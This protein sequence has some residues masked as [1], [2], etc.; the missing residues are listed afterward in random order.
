[1]PFATKYEGLAKQEVVVGAG[2]TLTSISNK[3]Y[4]SPM[5]WKLIWRTLIP[6]SVELYNLAD[7]PYERRD[8]AATRPEVLDEMKAALRRHVQRGGSVPWQ[9]RR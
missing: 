8:L 6:T 2:D 7:D 4:G 3:V 9:P 5:D 1:M